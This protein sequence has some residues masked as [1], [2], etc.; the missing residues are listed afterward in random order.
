MMV[1]VKIFEES[2]ELDLMDDINSF[3]KDFEKKEIIDIKYCSSN[4][5]AEE[6]IYSFSAMIIYCI[7]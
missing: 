6:Q 3:L 7:E 1:R 5:M 4:Y 2:H